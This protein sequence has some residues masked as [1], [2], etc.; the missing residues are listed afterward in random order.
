LEIRGA[1]YFIASRLADTLPA[2]VPDQMQME[3]SQINGNIVDKK[4]MLASART[5]KV[6]LTNYLWPARH[7]RYKPWIASI[8]LCCIFLCPQFTFATDYRLLLS[9]LETLEQKYA[10]KEMTRENILLTLRQSIQSE[11]DQD[12]NK[13]LLLR[14][15][16]EAQKHKS[17]DLSAFRNRLQTL[18]ALQAR[19]FRAETADS[20]RMNDILRRREFLVEE[21]TGLWDLIVRKIIN[22]IESFFQWLPV[23]D[24]LAFVSKLIMTIAL[25][26][27]SALLIYLILKF[28]RRAP[29]SPE[30]SPMIIK[31]QTMLSRP[32]HYLKLA[33]DALRAQDFRSACRHYF[34]AILSSLHHAGVISYQPSRTNW[35]YWRSLRS[36]PGCESEAQQFQL[37]VRDYEKF[38]Y[39][40]QV[41]DSKGAEAFRTTT[42]FFLERFL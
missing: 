36:K 19:K 25:A 13:T 1:T 21:D 40:N 42:Q 7:R 4:S 2:T 12:S 32:Q 6:F 14:D 28:T 16:L 22:W 5:S 20:K 34:Y 37:S 10:S 18:A 27:L 30:L 11:G 26:G 8:L 29:E 15:L 17:L 33:E 23:G 39:G 35:E 3:L 41:V 9:Q 31:R 38:W 24:Q